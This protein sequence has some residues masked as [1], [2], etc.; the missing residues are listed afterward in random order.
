MDLWFSVVFFHNLLILGQIAM[1]HAK[2]DVAFL[3]WFIDD[4]Y[5]DI[6]NCVI[7]ND[8]HPTPRGLVK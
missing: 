1:V 3:A 7:D 4:V 8:K 6:T 2:Y 5:G